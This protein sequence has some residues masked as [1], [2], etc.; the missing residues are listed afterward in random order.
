MINRNVAF[1]RNGKKNVSFRLIVI[2]FAKVEQ[3]VVCLSIGKRKHDV[4]IRLQ[5]ITTTDHV[6]TFIKGKNSW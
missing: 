5:C 3:L 4:V 6:G 1:Y 2:R